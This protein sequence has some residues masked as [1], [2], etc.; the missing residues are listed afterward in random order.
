MGTLNAAT[1]GVPSINVPLCFKVE[2]IPTMRALEDV[3]CAILVSSFDRAS[4]VNKHSINRRKHIGCSEYRNRRM[5]VSI[6]ITCLPFLIP[7]LIVT[8]ASFHDKILPIRFVISTLRGRRVLL[9]GL[10][11]S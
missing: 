3:C 10:S 11:D 8:G 7:Q 9:F 6:R 2:S 5:S 1:N 4:V